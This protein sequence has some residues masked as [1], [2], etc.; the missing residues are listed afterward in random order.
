MKQLLCKIIILLVISATSVFPQ[1]WSRMVV[2][3]W[4]NPPPP[5]FPGFFNPSYCDAESL[6]YFDSYFR[7]APSES[8]IYA[9]TF[10]GRYSGHWY[11]SDVVEF[12]A[13]INLPGYFS[14]SPNIN[15]GG[16]SMYFSSDRPGTR[17]GLDL[18]LSVRID[19]MWGDPINLGDSIN[20]EADELGPCYA[21]QSGILFFERY[22]NDSPEYDPHRILK[23]ISVDDVWQSPQSLPEVINEVNYYTYGPYFDEVEQ[24]LYFTNV[25][26]M[27]YISELKKSSLLDGEWQ[28]PTALTD[29]VNGFWYP[30]VCDGVTTEN[31]CMSFDR[32]LLFYSKWIWE[33]SYCIDFASILFVS[34]RMVGIDNGPVNLPG[35]IEY[36]SIYPNPFNSTIII[37]Y[38]NLDGN[39]FEVYDI[40]GRLVKSLQTGNQ[41]SGEITWN[42]TDND[43]HMVSSGIYFVRARTADGVAT[44]K[45][46][47]LK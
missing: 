2:I 41:S 47:Y 5:V 26:P 40:A 9:T 29:N 44:A 19:N 37:S 38:S 1:D 42:A 36:L 39:N 7:L 20:T 3:G 34:E 15:A 6:L 12:P 30:N 27:A 17:G 33:A 35:D 16:D 28:E 14:L 24:E 21:R 10:L 11:W 22:Q 13:P 46:V 45:L 8:K 4:D 43:G 25:S 18:W 31:A 23:A 32:D